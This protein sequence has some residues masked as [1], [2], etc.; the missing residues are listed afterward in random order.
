M[1]GGNEDVVRELLLCGNVSPNNKLFGH[2][3]KLAIPLITAVENNSLPLVQVLLQ[4][5]ADTSALS[6]EGR[7]ISVVYKI[8]FKFSCICISFTLSI[9]VQKC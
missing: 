2:S 1:I 4:Y 9:K 3:R 8:K 6:K 5:N 7:L